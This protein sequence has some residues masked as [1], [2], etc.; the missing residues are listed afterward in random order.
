MLGCGGAVG[1]AWSVVGADDS[2]R[3]CRGRGGVVGADDSVRP[4][5]DSR[6]HLFAPVG[7]NK[8]HC[9]PVRRLVRQSVLPLP[10]RALHPAVGDA[11]S[12]RARKERAPDRPRGN[13]RG[14]AG[15]VGHRFGMTG[16]TVFVAVCVSVV[17]PCGSMWASTPTT[18]CVPLPQ[19]AAILCRFALPHGGM[20]SSRPTKFTVPFPLNGGRT[21]SSAPTTR[22]RLS[23]VGRGRTPPLRNSPYPF[24]STA[25]GQGRPPLQRGCVLPSSGGVEAYRSPVLPFRHLLRKCHLPHRGRQGKLSGHVPFPLLYEKIPR[26]STIFLQE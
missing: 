13:M 19:N 5:G 20:R 17:H 6:P 1:C 18:E 8:C 25:G 26:L 24:L 16:A 3:P 4:C 22:V 7:G 12:S 23:I 21:G 11:D 14:H 15:D 10:H 2:V 9:E